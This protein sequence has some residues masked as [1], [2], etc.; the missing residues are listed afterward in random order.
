MQQ[1]GRL[2]SKVSWYRCGAKVRNFA[3]RGSV[4]FEV[5]TFGG[6]RKV[7]ETKLAKK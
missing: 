7:D 4:G 5:G 2:F 3:R 6:M 1:S